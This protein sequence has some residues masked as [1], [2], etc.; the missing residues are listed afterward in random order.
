MNLLDDITQLIDILGLSNIFGV[1]SGN[2][3]SIILGSFIVGY[4]CLTFKYKIYDNNERWT[5]LDQLEKGIVS[6]VVGFLSI[7]TSLYIV[8]IYQV[9]F[10]NN[11]DLEQ[12]ILQLKYVSPF[13]YF[14]CFSL[15]TAESKFEE[16]DFIKK[17]I[18]FSFYFIVI[19][20][21]LFA[22]IMLY[23]IRSWIGIFWMI[24]F[25][26]IILAPFIWREW[27]KY[28]SQRNDK[29]KTQN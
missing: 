27:L 28:S 21:F 7:L 18:R 29:N 5:N 22:L 15:S 19:L 13:L 16:F 4:T 25:I 17:Y 2:F 1:E 14:I 11:Y 24:I 10:L 9:T 26:L 23:A 12:F 8:T 20:N 6:L 3:L